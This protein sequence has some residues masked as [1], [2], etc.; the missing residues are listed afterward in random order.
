MKFEFPC[1]DIARL[2]GPTPCAAAFSNEG[3]FPSEVRTK[4]TTGCCS[5]RSELRTA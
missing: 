2:P 5:L 1:D 3:R 4:L